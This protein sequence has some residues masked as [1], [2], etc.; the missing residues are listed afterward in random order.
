MF[1][2]FCSAIQTDFRGNKATFDVISTSTE[3]ESFVTI[4]ITNIITISII[5]NDTKTNE[6]VFGQLKA[7][8]AFITTHV[9]RVS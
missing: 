7:D 3:I 4:E 6:C 9:R 8:E 2:R 1:G 5:V